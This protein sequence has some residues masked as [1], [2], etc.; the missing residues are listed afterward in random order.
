M[1]SLL[2]QRFILLLVLFNT[3]TLTGQSTASQQVSTFDIEVPQLNGERRIWVYL[4]EQYNA[5]NDVF[6]VMY[7]FDGQNIFDKE[8]SYAGEWEVD[9]YLDSI[10]ANHIIVAIDHGNK[11]RLNELTPYK[12][13]E[14]GGGQGDLFLEFIITRLKPHIDANYRTITNAEGT[15]IAGASL[16]GLMA[17]YAVINHQD[18]FSK[19]IAL[20]PSF[21]INPQ[22]VQLTEATKIKDSSRFYIVIGADEGELMLSGYQPLL[23]SLISKKLSPSQFYM[24]LVEGGRHNEEFWKAQF[25]QA[26]KWSFNQ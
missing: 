11:E 3:V 10:K 24:E 4:P 16:G 7:M 9:E 14:Y 21:W 23:E 13:P 25:K 22:I 1:S 8:S 6:P 19:A 15:S 20:S 18:V 5:S 17:Y 26:Y 12:N 2:V